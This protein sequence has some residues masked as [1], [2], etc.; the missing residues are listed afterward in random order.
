MFN[1]RRSTFTTAAALCL[2]GLLP[3]SASLQDGLTGYWPLNGDAL[4]H[5]ANQNHGTLLSGAS[6]VDNPSGPG[7]VLQTVL[8]DAHTGHVLVGL[9]AGMH[10]GNQV[11]GHKGS[12]SFWVRFDDREGRKGASGWQS[13]LGHPPGLLY[14]S[15]NLGSNKLWTMVKR[16]ERTGSNKNYWPQSATGS[17]DGEDVWRHVAWTFHSHN[18]GGE[19]HF[20][21]YIDGLLS[22]QFTSGVQTIGTSRFRIGANYNGQASNAKFA[23]VRLYDRVLGADEIRRLASVQRFDPPPLYPAWW[24]IPPAESLETAYRGGAIPPEDRAPLAIGQLKYLA[25]EAREELDAALAPVGGAGT[26]IGSLIDGFQTTDPDNLAPAVL[27]QLKYVS[28]KF[29]DR[30]AEVGFTPGEPGWPAGLVLDAGEGDNA[31]AYPWLENTS[32]ENLAPAAIGQAKFL[33]TWDVQPWF[34][35]RMAAD[36]NGDG[37]PDYWQALHAIDQPL[38]DADRDSFSNFVEAQ[39]GTSPNSGVPPADLKLPDYGSTGDGLRI[40]LDYRILAVTVADES[41]TL[42][43]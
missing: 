33:F 9:P 2:A 31:P 32:P 30:F 34:E 16:V 10:P 14:V 40:V 13:C 7:K 38:G 5:S 29:F 17:I 24:N 21:W 8:G 26:E 42:T 36:V 3:L 22:A 35:Q 37:L 27:S 18:Q 11:V 23:E 20:R 19:G 28:S 15:R 43:P 6:F 39:I 12:G 1:V 25:S 41:N 4:D